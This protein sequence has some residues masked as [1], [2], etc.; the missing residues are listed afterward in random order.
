MTGCTSEP[1]TSRSGLYDC[2]VIYILVANMPNFQEIP[3]E[4]NTILWISKLCLCASVKSCFSE[5]V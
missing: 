4:N 1:A 3:C 2:D 5:R